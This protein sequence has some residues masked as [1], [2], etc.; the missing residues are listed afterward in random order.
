MPNWWINYPSTIFK[1]IEANARVI[2]KEQMEENAKSFPKPDNW[3]RPI[4]IDVHTSTCATK[5][6]E[7]HPPTEIE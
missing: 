5:S 1:S 4:S 3:N 2:Y 7:K 6:K